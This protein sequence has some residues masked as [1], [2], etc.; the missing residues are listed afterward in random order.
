MSSP[1]TIAIDRTN[2]LGQYAN[3][4]RALLCIAPLVLISVLSKIGVPPFSTQGIGL[5]LPL[6]LLLTGVGV[7][8]GE[9]QLDC[10]R[11]VWA[12]ITLAVLGLLQLFKNDV[13]SS[14]SLALLAAIHVPFVWRLRRPLPDLAVVSNV[15]V[16]IAVLAAL[17]SI[18][19]FALQG[20]IAT[21]WLFPIDNF[22]PQAFL[23]QNFNQQAVLAYGSDVLRANGVFMLEPSYLSQLLALA[24]VLELATRQRKLISL[25]LGAAIVVSYSGT[26][27]MVLAISLPVLIITQRRWDILLLGVG[28]GLVAYVLSQVAADYLHIDNFAG[29]ATEFSYT[30]SSGFAR[31]V[32]GFY[33]FEQF[34]WDHPLRALFGVGAGM[35]KEYAAL[36]H[37][38]VAEMPLF[39]MVMEFGLVGAAVYFAFLIKCLSASSLPGAVALGIGITFLLNGLYVP[40]SHG[41]ALSLLMWTAGS[42]LMAKNTRPGKAHQAEATR[43]LATTPREFA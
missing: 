3:A 29:R 14:A 40:F 19:Q 20:L 5:T 33:L 23:L 36:A 9:L 37:V 25:L 8:F 7:L 22:V 35:F 1:G 43:A 12:G 18:A 13:F 30:G 32:G 34:L 26:G 42:T 4:L 24:L 15:F 39:K 31:F 6:L 11:F 16:G 21:R 38:P 10:T 41:I 28:A 17:F 2:W 27:M